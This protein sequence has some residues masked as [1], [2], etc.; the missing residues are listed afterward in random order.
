MIVDLYALPSSSNVII[1]S[2]SNKLEDYD[3]STLNLCPR[4]NSSKGNIR[5]SSQFPAQN[6][7]TN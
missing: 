1:V 4:C 5:G 3:T 6:K 2:D 7:L